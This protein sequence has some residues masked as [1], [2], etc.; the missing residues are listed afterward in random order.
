MRSKYDQGLHGLRVRPS[1]RSLEPLEPMHIRVTSQRAVKSTTQPPPEKDCLTDPARPITDGIV[2]TLNVD[3]EHL[4]SVTPKAPPS[5]LRAL[6]GP[7]I[8][9]PPSKDLRVMNF[10][11]LHGG[12]L[13]K[14]LL[15]GPLW[16]AC[17]NVGICSFPS[18][19]FPLFTHQFCPP[20]MEL[21]RVRELLSFSRQGQIVQ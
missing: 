18:S 1:S 21:L 3:S 6:D 9:F 17:W 2:R 20:G 8:S 19:M 12:Q 16:K 13:P 10:R 14:R 7:L 15:P 5:Q 4:S 11:G